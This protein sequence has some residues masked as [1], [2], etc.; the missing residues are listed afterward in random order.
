MD[1][2]TQCM[3]VHWVSLIFTW[4]NDKTD[5]TI[6]FQ[7]HQQKYFVF[8]DTPHI[9]L[10]SSQPSKQLLSHF[11]YA[12]MIKTML[13]AADDM[14]Q[15]LGCGKLVN[16]DC[17]CWTCE[18]NLHCFGSMVMQRA[19]S[20]LSVPTLHQTW[21]APAPSTSQQNNEAPTLKTA[22]ASTSHMATLMQDTSAP[23][24]SN[25]PEKRKGSAA[26]LPQSTSKRVKTS[27]ASSH[28]CKNKR[29]VPSDLNF[30]TYCIMLNK[31]HALTIMPQ[32]TLF[33]M[34]LW[35]VVHLINCAIFYTWKLM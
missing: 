33:T 1:R 22:A 10:I 11:A 19:W 5:V 31:G 13:N 17:I 20:T 34:E 6:R 23:G 24:S 27:A 35:L 2:Y 12:A 29:S 14:A 15:C 30:F 21:N 32:T 25:K 4:S 18:G 16:L 8:D 28:L 9:S 3:V 26:N 7:K